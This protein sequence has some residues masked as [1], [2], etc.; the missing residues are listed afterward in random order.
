MRILAVDYGTVRIGLAKS[1]ELGILASPLPCYHR[2][3]SVKK[4]AR[5][6]A[7]A[8][9]GLGVCQILLGYPLTL[10][11][12][13]GKMAKEAESFG[14]RI[15][16][17]TRIPVRMVDERYSSYQAESQLREAGRSSRKAKQ[18]MD[19]QSAVVLLQEYLDAKRN[20]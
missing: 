16:R 9:E 12:D 20:R 18:E 3:A 7:E 11:G 19:S 4:D 8:A 6:I 17:Y 5:S 10:Q 1:D 15:S 13:R 2:T 14:E